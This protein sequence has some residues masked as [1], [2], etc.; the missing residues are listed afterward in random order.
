M[1]TVIL[2]FNAHKKNAVVEKG[3]GAE[4]RRRRRSKYGPY[5]YI[6]NVRGTISVREWMITANNFMFGRVLVSRQCFC[7]ACM[8]NQVLYCT[9]LLC[10]G[11]PGGQKL[12]DTLR[13]YLPYRQFA[14]AFALVD[15][16]CN[17]ITCKTKISYFTCMII[18]DE[19]VA[20]R[21][22]TMNNLDERKKTSEKKINIWF[23]ENG[24]KDCDDNSMST[25][26]QRIVL[27]RKFNFKILW[28]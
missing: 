22:I 14:F 2:H 6:W 18:R 24:K 9:C 12:P 16:R 3:E 13:F 20:G 11:N 8:W 27:S 10:I 15:F 19:Y 23:S 26:H 4:G 1:K 17:H 7:R 21:Q 28:K 25:M 5:V